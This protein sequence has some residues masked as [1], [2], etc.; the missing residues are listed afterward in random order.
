MMMRLESNIQLNQNQAHKCL[1][2]LRKKSQF[3]N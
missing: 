3:Q 1:K 2:Q